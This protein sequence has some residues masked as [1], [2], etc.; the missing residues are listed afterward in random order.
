ME[1]RASVKIHES[2]RTHK[3]TRILVPRCV[4]IDIPGKRG[5]LSE[6]FQNV[7]VCA[8]LL[9]ISVI[10]RYGKCKPSAMAILWEPFQQ[11]SKPKMSSKLVWVENRVPMGWHILPNKIRWY[12]HIQYVSTSKVI[13]TPGVQPNEWQ[14]KYCS[15]PIIKELAMENPTF[16]SMKLV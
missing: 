8:Y 7:C 6:I 13:H 11:R 15:P 14:K 12:Q 3:L 1:F 2:S 10:K 5:K 4:D 16:S 9:K